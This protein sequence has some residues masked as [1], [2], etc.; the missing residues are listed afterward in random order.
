VAVSGLKKFGF[1]EQ[2]FGNFYPQ[3]ALDKW[4]IPQSSRATERPAT[5]T[6][7]SE[8]LRPLTVPLRN[9]PIE[10]RTLEMATDNRGR[11]S[12]MEGMVPDPASVRERFDSERFCEVPRVLGVLWV[13]G[14]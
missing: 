7:E 13:R 5:R 11:R 1:W 14:S 6:V 2:L 8:S 4:H 12:L 9:V 10:K 3:K